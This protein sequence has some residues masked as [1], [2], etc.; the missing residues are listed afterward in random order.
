MVTPDPKS[1]F[2]RDIQVFDSFEE[3]EAQER[4]EWMQ[5]P[6]QERMVLL[7]QLRAQSYPDERS[8]PQGL[9]RVLAIID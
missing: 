5:M 1:G 9:Q 7:E 3:A 2:T 6:R 8:H 4:A